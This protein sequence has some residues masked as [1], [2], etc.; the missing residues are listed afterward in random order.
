MNEARKQY[1]TS[2]Q[3]QQ[4]CK[5]MINGNWTQASEEVVEYGF[6]E[7]DLLNE[8]DEALLAEMLFDEDA[9]ILRGL[10]TVVQM[11]TRKRYEGKE[12]NDDNV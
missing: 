11:A 12:A 3:F 7:N 1:R 5:S 8:Y 2:E 6:W 10:V 4:V 9:Y